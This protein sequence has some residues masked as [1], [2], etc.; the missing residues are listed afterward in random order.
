MPAHHLGSGGHFL[1]ADPVALVLALH[2]QEWVQVLKAVRGPLSVGQSQQALT[3]IC[4]DCY[5][6]APHRTKPHAIYAHL[7]ALP[8]QP[9]FQQKDQGICQGLEVVSPASGAAQVCMH[10]GIPDCA[11]EVIWLLV[12]LDMAIP[13]PPLHSCK[14]MGGW[15]SESQNYTDATRG[16]SAPKP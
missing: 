2:T 9:P 4:G 7:I 3:R 6:N 1:F 10:T 15:V 8:R 11:P 16:K 14:W 13:V 5:A 12:V